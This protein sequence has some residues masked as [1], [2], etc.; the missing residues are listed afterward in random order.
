MRLQGDGP[1]ARDPQVPPPQIP[2]PGHTK[3]TWFQLEAADKA[4]WQKVGSD[5][6]GGCKADHTTPT[7]VTKFEEAF[8]K[9]TFD[10]DVRQHLHFLQHNSSNNTG[11]S[12]LQNRI[13]NLE[14]QLSGQKRKFDVFNDKGKGRGKGKGK[15]DDKGKGKG[16]RR[17]QKGGAAVPPAFGGLPGTTPAGASLC[18]NF[19]LA[20]GCPHAQ[21]GEQCHRGWHLCPRCVQRPGGEREALL[22]N[23]RGQ[24]TIFGPAR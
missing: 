12:R 10:P 18:Y 20:V 8:K 22:D 6:E 7:A 15:N 11:V 2:P 1:L 13:V 4:L 9:A 5:C 19:N 14:Q 21:K 17:G 23:L 16:K 24:V 3:V